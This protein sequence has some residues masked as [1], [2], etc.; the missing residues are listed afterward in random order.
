VPASGGFS[1][2]LRLYWPK[3]EALDRRWAPPP[4]RRVG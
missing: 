4:V 2:N 1:L 3:A